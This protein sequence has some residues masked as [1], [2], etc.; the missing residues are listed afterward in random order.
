MNSF[1]ECVGPLVEFQKSILCFMAIFVVKNI[2]WTYVQEKFG[3][4]HSTDPSSSSSETIWIKIDLNGDYQ[5][6][7]DET[8]S[9]HIGSIAYA[10]IL[11]FAC[12]R[13]LI[14]TI[15]FLLCCFCFFIAIFIVVTFFYDRLSEFDEGISH[16]VNCKQ[17][18]N[19]GERCDEI[20]RV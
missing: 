8:Q 17:C 3:I 9:I 10:H 20:R 11:D 2:G 16:S 5:I 12:Q 19:E 18:R 6:E 13:R 4:L 15:L 7:K 1:Q 14:G